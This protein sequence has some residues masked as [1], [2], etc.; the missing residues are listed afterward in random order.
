MQK[1]LILILFLICINYN[2]IEAQKIDSSLQYRWPNSN[3]DTMQWPLTYGW[4]D[5]TRVSIMEEGDLWI[6][7][8]IKKTVLVET[9]GWRVCENYPT[10]PDCSCLPKH[11]FVEFLDEQKHR[12]SKTA[13]IKTSWELKN[14]R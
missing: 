5:T 13:V 7:D 1:Y 2:F 12:F 10:P 9:N 3:R 11:I 8:T 14:Q 6:M 4:Y